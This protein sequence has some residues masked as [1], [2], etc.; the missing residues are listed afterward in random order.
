MFVPARLPALRPARWRK[1][2]GLFVAAY[3]V[4]NGAR[5]LFAGDRTVAL[6]HARWILDLERSAG[7]AV[8]GS[9]Q[10]A[11]DS[12]VATWVLSHIYLAAQLVVLPLV[13]IWVY[14]QSTP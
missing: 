11:L 8:E 5:W 7:L 4:Y 14:R 1:E 9:V 13:L 3:L 2:L 6:D 10:D 12:S